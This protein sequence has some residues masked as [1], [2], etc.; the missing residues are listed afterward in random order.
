MQWNVK[1]TK[2]GNYA[3]QIGVV[4]KIGKIVY[5]RKSK[6]YKKYWRKDNPKT[7]QADYHIEDMVQNW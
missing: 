5:E 1:R 6:Q 2:I 7:S 3:P 4:N